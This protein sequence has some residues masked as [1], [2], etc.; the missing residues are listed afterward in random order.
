MTSAKPRPGYVVSV[1]VRLRRPTAYGGRALHH[2]SPPSSVPERPDRSRTPEI[3]ADAHALLGLPLVIGGV[4]GSQSDHPPADAN[5]SQIGS[6]S[7]SFS[8]MPHTSA[9]LLSAIWNTFTK[10][11]STLLPLGAVTTA[12]PSTTV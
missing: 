12:V 3:R 7:A 11:Y 2:D 6:V 1:G 4:S 8:D 9:T 10:L 5:S